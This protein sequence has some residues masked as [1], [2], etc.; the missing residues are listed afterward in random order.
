MKLIIRTN[1]KYGKW[2]KNHLEHEHPKTKGHI[3]MRK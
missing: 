3:K 1:P 2:L